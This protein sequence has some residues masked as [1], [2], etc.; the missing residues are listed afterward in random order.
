M[1]GKPKSAARFTA[2][3]DNSTSSEGGLCDAHSKNVSINFKDPAASRPG[4][5][6]EQSTIRFSSGAWKDL[7]M[8]FAKDHD[9]ADGFTMKADESRFRLVDRAVPNPAGLE[10]STSF[11]FNSEKGSLEAT[12]MLK[13][14]Q[15]HQRSRR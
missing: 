12:E 8:R 3:E 4:R 2:S 15:A 1:P 13:S 6:K 5:P 9:L 10:Y 14:P 11:L 7:A